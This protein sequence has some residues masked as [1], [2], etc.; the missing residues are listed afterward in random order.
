M[1]IS[2]NENNETY[3]IHSSNKD[4]SLREHVIKAKTNFPARLL[5]WVLVAGQS[6]KGIKNVM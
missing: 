4:S 5:V 6:A 1:S 2:L 3:G